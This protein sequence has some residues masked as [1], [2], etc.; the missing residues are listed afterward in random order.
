[1]PPG[2]GETRHLHRRARQVFFVLSGTATFELGDQ[3]FVLGPQEGIEVSPE[4][5][6]L[7]RN[8]GAVDLEFLVIAQPDSLGDRE[9]A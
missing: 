7:I 4:V 5:P 2:R 9:P 8:D 1:M 6:H 3:T